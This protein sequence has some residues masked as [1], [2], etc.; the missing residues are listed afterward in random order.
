VTESLQENLGEISE[1]LFF[2]L[3]AMTIVEIIDAHEGFSAITDKITT[4]NRV[5]LLRILCLL[6][7]F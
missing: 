2:L 7:F 3:G 4:I 6:A 5:K 1:I